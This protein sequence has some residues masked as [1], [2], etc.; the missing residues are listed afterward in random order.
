M[1]I[2]KIFSIIR[3]CRCS[4]VS[5]VSWLVLMTARPLVASY[6]MCF[7]WNCSNMPILSSVNSTPWNSDGTGVWFYHPTNS[8][9]AHNRCLRSVQRMRAQG[10]RLTRESLARGPGGVIRVYCLEKFHEWGGGEVRSVSR[11]LPA[12]SPRVS[13]S[14]WQSVLAFLI[15]AKQML[16]CYS[17]KLYACIQLS[18]AYGR[19]E[20]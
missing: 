16:G 19:V 6:V 2:F 12:R 9:T 11:G 20:A 3:A 18:A 14:A 15:P 4:L 1:P 7:L 17:S 13:R 10:T 8:W 5:A